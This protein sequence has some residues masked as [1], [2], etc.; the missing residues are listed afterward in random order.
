MLLETG[1]MT[2]G[3]CVSPPTEAAYLKISGM[4]CAGCASSVTRILNHLPGIQLADVNFAAEQARVIFD[5]HQ[6][7]LSEVIEKIKSLGFGAT[8]LQESLNQDPD[9]ATEEA[10]TIAW[11]RLW[12]G[13][14][15]ALMLMAVMLYC[16]IMD[17]PHNEHHRI[18]T[19][20]LAFPVVFIAGW[21]T[22]TAS[23]AALRRGS[24]NMDVL[25]TLGTVPTYLAG[26]LQ[27]SEVTVFVEVAAMVMAFHL[28]SRYLE[29]RA[30]GRASQSIR[31][32]LRLRV[33]TAH[34][35]RDPIGD[36][37]ILES[38]VSMNSVD[39][40]LEM[41]QVGDRLWIKPGEMIPLDGQVVFGQSTVDESMATGESMPVVKHVGDAV[42]GST[43]NQN[44]VLL[45][46]V[47]RTGSDTFLAQMIRLVQEA[48]GSRIPIQTLADQITGYFVP[49]V[50]ALAGSTFLLWLVAASALHPYLEQMAQIFP[51]I[52]L[53][54]SRVSLAAF[55]M[56]AVLVV[57]CPCALGL[58]TPVALMV[59]AGRG[60]EQ[61]ILIRNGEAIQ[62]LKS[63][64]T[65]LLDKT[66]TLTQGKPELTQVLPEEKRLEILAW[67]AAA[68]QGSEHPLGQTILAAATREHLDLPAVESFEAI[69]GQGIRAQIQGKTL[70]VGSPTFLTSYADT[71]S[72]LSWEDP[73]KDLEQSGQTVVG[74]LMDG[75]V[76]GILA[77]ADPVKPDSW[78]AIQQLKA[79]GLDPIMVSG[80]SEGVAQAIA[81]DLGIQQVYA[82]LLPGGKVD[83][84][85][86]LQS[87]NQVVAFVGDGLN[88]AP[89]LSQAQV[90]IAIGTGSDLAIE[91][92]DLAIVQG[93]LTTVVR[94]IV[95]A[96]ATFQKIQTNLLGAYFYNLLAIP[97]AAA[98]LIHPI[99]AEVAMALSSLTVIWSSL[100]LHSI[101]LDPKLDLDLG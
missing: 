56:I 40:P 91:A 12:L 97:L 51:W 1:S 78:T 29:Q 52:P 22:H 95:L 66:G 74:V 64:T 89:A 43:L 99:M 96:K 67:A 4:S 37:S 53:H 59:G 61:G 36:E 17:L 98:G 33:K 93:R 71:G 83:V 5:P 47:T 14:I 70:Y 57:A 16:L 38:S 18:L 24:P 75:R 35:Q 49:V 28:I 26:L 94:A 100:Q 15:P 73:I 55:N 2:V 23:W 39:V 84:I 25:I 81:K 8:P 34:L 63:M 3:T 62:A 32:L 7:T 82:G 68:E 31:K 45:I 27:V 21:P 46:E 87:Q 76:L 86:A 77:L 20:S 69:I 42:I 44:G 10:I 50:V 30:R 41:I 13:A 60:A 6:I 19:L 58:A 65:I 88:D 54:L 79:M 101:D 85:K 48:Q 80:D 72:L 11:N 92:A 90:G 9:A